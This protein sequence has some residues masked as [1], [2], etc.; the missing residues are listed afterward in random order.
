[1]AARQ[2]SRHGPGNSPGTGIEAPP[3][4]G[5]SRHRR[6]HAR[7]LSCDESGPLLLKISGSACSPGFG[8]HLHVPTCLAPEEALT[9][10]VACSC[11]RGVSRWF[12]LC[13]LGLCSWFSGLVRTC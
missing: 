12:G 4:T 3:P 7:Q 13:S 6:P 8:T 11:L 10:A 1:M 9:R 2:Q 5:N